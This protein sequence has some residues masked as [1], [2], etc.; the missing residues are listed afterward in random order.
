MADPE[1]EGILTEL[2][3][4]YEELRA[5]RRRLAELLP[6]SATK[7]GDSGQARVDFV[8]GLARETDDELSGEELIRKVSAE[9]WEQAQRALVNA[10]EKV[11]LA[12]HH[13][14]KRLREEP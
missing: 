6:M 9:A 14:R 13:L 4:A 12:H 8:T 5:A 1:I 2:D 10:A 7:P 3:E 11:E